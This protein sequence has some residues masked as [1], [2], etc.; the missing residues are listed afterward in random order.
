MNDTRP[1]GQVTG[2]FTGKVATPWK[3]RAPSAIAKTAALGP[4]HITS[5]GLEGDEQ[6]DLS[7]HGGPDQAVHH[8][9][10]EHF[11]VWASKFPEDADKFAP[12]CFGENVSSTGLTEQNLCIGDVLKIGTAL[13]Q[14]T[15]GRQPC[16]KLD[17]H[18]QRTDMAYQFRKTGRTGW[19][20]R[21]LEP[22]MVDVGAAIELQD[23]PCPDWSIADVTHARFTPNLDVSLAG[24]LATLEPLSAVWRDIFLKRADG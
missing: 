12:G 6:A 1:T 16:W 13:L 17:A 9:A 7:V 5:H 21:V 20:Y 22:G 4:L 11:D 24:T 23:R 18:M 19:Y 3:D 2:L 15:Q 14:V 10:I 8:Y